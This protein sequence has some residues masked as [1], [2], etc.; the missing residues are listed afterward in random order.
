M[1][2][3]VVTPL[4]VC[5]APAASTAHS[6]EIKQH[7]VNVGAE[8]LTGVDSL[9]STVKRS[10][11]IDSFLAI[12]STSFSCSTQAVP[13]IYA[14]TETGCQVIITEMSGNHL[15]LAC[16]VFHYCQADGRMDS[17]FCPNLTLFNQQYFVC[18]W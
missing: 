8:D 15:P 7:L 10:A 6:R 9:D 5:A 3:Q 12:P 17:F 14:D 18:D 2:V 16:Q 4:L 11:R 13:G 1:L